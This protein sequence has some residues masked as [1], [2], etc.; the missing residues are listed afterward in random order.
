MTIPEASHRHAAH[1]RTALNK[2][3]AMA[4]TLE[5]WELSTQKDGV[6]LY[7]K[8]VEGSPLPMVRGEVTLKGDEFTP[9]N[10]ASVALDP[11]CRKIWDDRYDVSDTKEWF[12]S[13]E[14]LTWVKLKA[15]WPVSPRD[16]SVATIR[17]IGEDEC[18]V[19]ISSVEDSMTPPV[20]GCVRGNLIISGWRLY[21]VP[22]GVA[23]TY[24]TQVD[25]AGSIPSALLKAIQIQV[26]LCAGKVIDYINSYGFP[27]I[28]E[29]ATAKFKSESFDHLKRTLVSEFEGQGEVRYIASNKMYPNG[30][31]VSIN[32]SATHEILPADR[33]NKLIVVK[34]IN[35]PVSITISKA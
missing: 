16:F 24:I 18:N 25:L 11:G 1:N 23:I 9:R 2:F 21:R 10:V 30:V 28:N 31:K 27:P 34:N 22:E 35:G 20:S 3:K 13:T 29:S 6:K 15:P 8:A 5:G 4:A 26:P 17:D 7:T 12:S 14:S 33:K 32:G 19:V